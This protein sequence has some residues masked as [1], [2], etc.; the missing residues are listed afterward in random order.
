MNH[1]L[2]E[3]L[4]IITDA[5]GASIRCMKCLHVLCRADQDWRAASKRR[6]FPPT[7][8]GPC[9]TDLLGH[10]LLEQLYCPSCGALLNTDLVEEKTLGEEKTNDDPI[11][12][13]QTGT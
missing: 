3:N 1:A 12:T 11:R 2:R 4:E 10:F 9:M 6:L 7:K 13:K 8:A 5:R